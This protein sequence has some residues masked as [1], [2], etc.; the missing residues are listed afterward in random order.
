MKFKFILLSLVILLVCSGCT[1]EYNLDIDDKL[2]L[3][4]SIAIKSYDFDEIEEIRDY[5]TFLPISIEADDYS[6]YEQKKDGVEYYNI[7]KNDDNSEI[8]FDYS[9]NVDMFNENRFAR[10]CYEYVT[11]MSNY[12][13]EEKRNE[14]LLSTSKKFLFFKNQEDLESVTIKIH[15]DRE[16][17]SNNADSVDGNT[18]IWNI[19]KDNKNDAGISMVLSSDILEKEISFWEKNLLWILTFIFFC[20]VGIVY[21]YLKNKSEKADKI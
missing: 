14:L 2:N 5:N 9:Y 15:T 8:K 17:Y 4:E 7:T 6:V 1:V 21:L 10:S 16:V 11:V 18:Y 19:T 3:N 12:D 13:Q 20:V